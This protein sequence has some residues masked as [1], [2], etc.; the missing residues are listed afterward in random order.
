MRP[1]CGLHCKIDRVVGKL[2][3]IAVLSSLTG[4]ACAKARANTEIVM[5]ELVPPPPPPR[6]VEA[7]PIDPVPTIEPSPVE[8]ALA[9]P[10][11]KTPSRP[12][13]KP[14]PPKVDEVPSAP[15]PPAPAAPALTLKPGSSVQAQT[16]ASIRNWL[17]RAARDLARVKYAA[18]NA[19]GRAQFD[20]ARGFMQRAEEALKA[21]N[22]AFAG[23][24][25]DKA[26]TM[27]AVL[28]R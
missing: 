10:P 1:L 7:F 17:D 16:E 24:L 22:L 5:P 18:L 21:G 28:V 9:A 11:A 25:A 12:I 6:I 3:I 19:D 13:T 15:E 8:S 4:A 14:E 27:A 20:I 23:K 2:I 26:A